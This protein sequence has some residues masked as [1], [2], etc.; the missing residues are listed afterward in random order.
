MLP[1]AAVSKPDWSLR[2]PSWVAVPTYVLETDTARWLSLLL[3]KVLTQQ[4][5]L[6]HGICTCKNKTKK[7]DSAGYAEDKPGLETTDPV[8]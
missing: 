1:G 4:A 8:N 5:G 6:G 2:P 7:H 3:P